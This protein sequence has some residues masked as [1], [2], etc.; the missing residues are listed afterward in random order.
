MC[1]IAATGADYHDVTLDTFSLLVDY[2]P[3]KRVDLYAG[4]ALSNVY[5]GLAS[6]F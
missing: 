6:G 4:V 1:D 3:V 5:V 2:R